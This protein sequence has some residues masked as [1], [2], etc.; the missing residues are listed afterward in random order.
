M[1]YFYSTMLI[2]MRR[3]CFHCPAGDVNLFLSDLKVETLH[4]SHA[5]Y[6]DEDNG[7]GVACACAYLALWCHGQVS[8]LSWC[9]FIPS[10]VPSYPSTSMLN[11]SSECSALTQMQTSKNDV[12]DSS[13]KFVAIM[14]GCAI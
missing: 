1:D 14:H 5:S 8:L 3:S 12:A 7:Q 2:A 6:F 4:T 13:S 9:T 11:F 10:F